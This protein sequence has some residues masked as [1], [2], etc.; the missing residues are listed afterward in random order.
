MMYQEGV[1]TRKYQDELL[2]NLD[3]DGIIITDRELM[4][5]AILRMGFGL[6][7]IIEIGEPGDMLC[8]DDEPIGIATEATMESGGLLP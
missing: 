5:K 7:T 3:G 4:E 8:P 1:F 6:D 2:D